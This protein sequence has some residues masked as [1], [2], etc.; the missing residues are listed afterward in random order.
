M[1]DPTVGSNKYMVVTGTLNLYGFGPTTVWTRLTA[2]AAAGA[3]TISVASTAGW[4]VGDEIVI[5]PTFKNPNATDRVTITAL[6][7]TSVTF[8]QALNWT[9]YG[10]ATPLTNS[11]GTLDMRAA[12]GHITRKLK[13]VAGADAGYGFRVLVYGMM[14]GNKTR[15]GTVSLKGV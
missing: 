7:S 1:I 5:G 15:L 8:S 13:I 4:A 9:H 3:T 12:V 6:T 2:K 10:D 14:D 11:Y